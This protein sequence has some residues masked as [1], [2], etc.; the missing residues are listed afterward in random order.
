MCSIENL[1]L[2]KQYICKEITNFEPQPTRGDKL[3]QLEIFINNLINDDLQGILCSYS[4]VQ[5]LKQQTIEYERALKELK[6]KI[7]DIRI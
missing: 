2:I 5:F 7:P 1:E 4:R 3:H 6:D